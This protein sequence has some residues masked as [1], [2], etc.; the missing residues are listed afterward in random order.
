MSLLQKSFIWSTVHCNCYQDF[1]R[2]CELCHITPFS[3]G[4][5][6]D[7][8]DFYETFLYKDNTGLPM[9]QCTAEYGLCSRK[10]SISSFPSAKSTK[11]CLY[12]FCDRLVLFFCGRSNQNH[13]GSSGHGDHCGREHCVS[14]PGRQWPRP[15]CFLLL[16]LQWTADRQGRWSLWACGRSEW[17][18]VIL[19]SEC[20]NG[21]LAPLSISFH[22]IPVIS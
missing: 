1:R 15:W 19:L 7:I 8:R 2:L 20:A 22:S 13:P 17:S 4:S 11:V 14:L 3:I 5:L 21:R 18:E 9:S 16:G 6:H 12:N 10:C